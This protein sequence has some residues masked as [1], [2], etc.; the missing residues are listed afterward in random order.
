MIY[1]KVEIYQSHFAKG[2][3]SIKKKIIIKPRVF[4]IHLGLS[5]NIYIKVVAMKIETYQPL[6]NKVNVAV[7]KHVGGVMVG[8]FASSAVDRWFEPCSGQTKE[9]ALR[10]N[11]K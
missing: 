4:G 3:T 1:T 8:M 2:E 11:S 9:P 6:G 5:R 10:S 7:K